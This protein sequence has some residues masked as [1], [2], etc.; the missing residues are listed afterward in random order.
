MMNKAF[1]KKFD[2][3]YTFINIEKNVLMEKWIY[4]CFQEKGKENQYYIEKYS[5]FT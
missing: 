4:M 5:E 2:I 3:L 1:F